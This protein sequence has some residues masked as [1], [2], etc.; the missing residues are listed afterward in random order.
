M[1]LLIYRDTKFDEAL[2]ALRRKGGKASN[3]ARKAERIISNLCGRNQNLNSA[4]KLTENGERRIKYCRK[5]EL[6]SGYRLICIQ[7]GSYLIFAYAGDHDECSRWI[8]HNKKL[9]YEIEDVLQ[10][11]R[12]VY[13][14]L[15]SDDDSISEDVLPEDALE[16]R[17]FAAEYEESLMKRIED[18][19][20][21]GI[22][23]CWFQDKRQKK[24]N[25]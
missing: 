15:D 8:E 23:S 24:D 20:L 17:K 25:G 1:N 16:E 14:V 13:E 10:T 7:Q 22:F 5:Y 2:G 21:Q 19:A 12:P 6:G 3:A 11:A 4:G 18:N 9:R